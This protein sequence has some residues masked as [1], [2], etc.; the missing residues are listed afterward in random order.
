MV[1]NETIGSA[2]M[3]GIQSVKAMSGGDWTQ[4]LDTMRTGGGRVLSPNLRRQIE[5]C[6]GRRELLD[7]QIK[8]D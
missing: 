6:F 8:G 7:D 2:G 3:Q 4:Q 5:R 1:F